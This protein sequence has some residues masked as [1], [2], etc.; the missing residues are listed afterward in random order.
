MDALIKSA[1]VPWTHNALRHTFASMHYATH[2]NPAVL[3]VQM[4]HSEGEE[5][6]HQHY[7]ATKTTSGEVITKRMAEDFWTLTPARVRDLR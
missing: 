4:G 5:V 1:G 2:Q 3:R 7:R 6:L